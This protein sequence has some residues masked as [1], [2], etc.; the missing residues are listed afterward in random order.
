MPVISNSRMVRARIE[1]NAVKSPTADRRWKDVLERL[2]N[3]PEHQDM[4]VFNCKPI[5]EDLCEKT[6]LG[7][8]KGSDEQ[9]RCARNVHVRWF[10][11]GNWCL[12]HRDFVDPR[13]DPIG[14]LVC[15]VLNDPFNSCRSRKQSL[16][17]WKRSEF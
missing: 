13:E 8:P 12:V 3:L 5:P 11:N 9:Y 1:R 10:K 17:K 16:S 2:E 4:F 6:S 15:D 14:H 7:W